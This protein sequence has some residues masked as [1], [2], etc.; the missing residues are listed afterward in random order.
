M[1]WMKLLGLLEMKVEMF[2]KQLL[3]SIFQPF[4]CCKI[5]YLLSHVNSI[6]GLCGLILRVGTG[7]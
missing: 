3:V 5:S 7:F 4:I 6:T 1:G 2:D